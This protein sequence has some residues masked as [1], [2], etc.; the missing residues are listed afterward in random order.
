MNKSYLKKLIATFLVIVLCMTTFAFAADTDDKGQKTS[1]HINITKVQR[2]SR[3]S[4]STDKRKIIDDIIAE[5]EDEI[6]KIVKKAEDSLKKL[7]KQI[8]KWQDFLSKHKNKLDKLYKS[9]KYRK[10]FN[11]YIEAQQKRGKIFL[12]TFEEILNKVTDKVEDR[13]ITINSDDI[14]YICRKIS[15]LISP[16]LYNQDKTDLKESFC[17]FI[18]S[19]YHSRPIPINITP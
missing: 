9:A 16:R 4:E 10:D 2:K 3:P 6:E 17:I 1:A 18:D 14:I 19:K 11:D 7:E 13:K 5:L 12:Q 15:K 8:K